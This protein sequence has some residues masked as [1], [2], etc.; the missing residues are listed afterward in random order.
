MTYSFNYT[1]NDIVNLFKLIASKSWKSKLIFV[2]YIYLGLISLFFL[3]HN[4]SYSIG[5]ALSILQIYLLL[6]RIQLIRIR[7]VYLTHPGITTITIE[8]S[9]LIFQDSSQKVEIPLNQIH[10]VHDDKDSILVFYG[11]GINN[12]LIPKRVIATEDEINNL[13]SILHK[14]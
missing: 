13:V 2:L 3:F 12:I 11:A 6:Q 1:E 10:K 5:T 9:K 8:D 4:L 7:N 14:L